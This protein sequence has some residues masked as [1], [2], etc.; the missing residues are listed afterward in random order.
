LDQRHVPRQTFSA[1]PPHGPSI[2]RVR[3]AYVGTEHQRLADLLNWLRRRSVIVALICVALVIGFVAYV[4]W[5]LGQP[6]NV[7]GL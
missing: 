5:D 3:S 7:S 1:G 2:R 6:N 4:T